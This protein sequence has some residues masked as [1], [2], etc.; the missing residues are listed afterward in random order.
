MG[1]STIKLPI[2]IVSSACHQVMPASIM[3]AASMYVGMHTLMPT[4]SAPMFQVLHVRA[5]DLAAFDRALTGHR[6]N[7]DAAA[8]LLDAGQF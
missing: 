3:P 2:R 8:R 6:S 1:T 5:H 4:H 7:A